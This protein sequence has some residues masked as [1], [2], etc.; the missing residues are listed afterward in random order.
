MAVPKVLAG[1][2]GMEKW[3]IQRKFEFPGKTGFRKLLPWALI[4]KGR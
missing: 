3:R 2:V 4:A 1:P